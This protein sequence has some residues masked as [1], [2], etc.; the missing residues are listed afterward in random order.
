MFSVEQLTSR[1]KR[2]STGTFINKQLSWQ[3]L[4]DADRI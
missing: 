2:T 4:H 1:I 3:D